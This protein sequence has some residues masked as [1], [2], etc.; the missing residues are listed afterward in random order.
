MWQDY[1]DKDLSLGTHRHKILAKSL[2][3]ACR[4]GSEDATGE[5]ATGVYVSSSLSLIL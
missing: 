2:S 5:R 4:T 3:E 1:D